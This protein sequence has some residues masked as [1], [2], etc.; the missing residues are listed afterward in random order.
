MFNLLGVTLLQPEPVISARVPGGAEAIGAL[1]TT[2]QDLLRS[3]YDDTTTSGSRTL[4]LALGPRRRIQLWLAAPPDDAAS[5]D[6]QALLRELSERIVAPEVHDG[7]VALAVV[8][9]IGAEPPAE[10]QL[11]LPDE[12]HA[13]IQASDTTL[14]VEQIITR[15]WAS[16]A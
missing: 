3:R 4:C 2:I 14:N 6:E 9:A 1:L 11:V 8:F 12:W 13:I 10:A 16:S 15:L 5:E 7:P